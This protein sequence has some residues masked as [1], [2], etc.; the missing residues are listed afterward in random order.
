MKLSWQHSYMVYLFL[1]AWGQHRF[2]AIWLTHRYVYTHTQTAY[3]R[4]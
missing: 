3:D 4:L 1:F 2:D